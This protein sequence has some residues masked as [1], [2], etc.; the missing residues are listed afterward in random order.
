[1]DLDPDKVTN[2]LADAAIQAEMFK[3]FQAE[4]GAPTEPIPGG[5]PSPSDPT[6]AGDGN[7]G[8]GQIPLPNEQGFSGNVQ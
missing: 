8:M 3:G 6:G 2:S 5:P 7:I 1:M 4:A